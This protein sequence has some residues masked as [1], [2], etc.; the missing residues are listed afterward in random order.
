MNVF[1]LFIIGTLFV[2]MEYVHNGEIINQEAAYSSAVT[3][4]QLFEEVIAGN[5]LTS[6]SFMING[7]DNFAYLGFLHCEGDLNHDGKVDIFDLL[8]FL[9]LWGSDSYQADFDDDGD[10]DVYDLLILL[11]NWGSC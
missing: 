7:S 4:P 2:G 9:A 8:E 10:V 11:Y 6:L 3:T 5:P 1:A